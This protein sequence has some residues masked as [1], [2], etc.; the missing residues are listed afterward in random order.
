MSLYLDIHGC[1]EG[2]QG[3]ALALTLD[4]A[5]ILQNHRAIFTTK[6]NFA[7]H[8]NNSVDAHVDTVLPVYVDKLRAVIFLLT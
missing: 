7:P 4:F 6:K 2:K 8:K 5:S 1:P 3:R